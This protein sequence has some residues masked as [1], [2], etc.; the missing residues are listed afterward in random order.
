MGV[1]A[2]LVAVIGMVLLT[3]ATVPFVFATASTSE[4]L[5]GVVLVIRGTGLGLVLVPI[6]AAAYIGLPHSA[7]PS[8]TTGVRRSPHDQAD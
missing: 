8:A 2:R 4:A 1:S 5:L 3:V 6:T 7:I